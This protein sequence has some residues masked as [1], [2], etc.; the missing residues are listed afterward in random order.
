MLED[1]VFSQPFTQKDQ[2]TKKGED[3]DRV[4]DHGI[5][6]ITFSEKPRKGSIR[7]FKTSS[8]IERQSIDNPCPNSTGVNF[9]APLHFRLL[10]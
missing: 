3:I 6:D 10:L 7:N 2:T 4:L 5:E 1:S 8:Y 9:Y